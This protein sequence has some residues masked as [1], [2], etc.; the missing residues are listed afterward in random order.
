M[1]PA[2]HLQNTAYSTLIEQTTL[3]FVMTVF[4]LKFVPKCLLVECKWLKINFS[5]FYAC[6]SVVRTPSVKGG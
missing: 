1:V 6:G 4:Q 3:K 5:E 2:R